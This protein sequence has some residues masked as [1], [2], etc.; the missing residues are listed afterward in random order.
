MLGE[1]SPHSRSQGWKTLNQGATLKA[2]GLWA[3]VGQWPCDCDGTVPAARHLILDKGSRQ[4]RNFAWRPDSTALT[5]WKAWYSDQCCETVVS[6]CIK[7]YWQRS[8]H[9]GNV[10]MP[11]GATSLLASHLC[12]RRSSKHFHVLWQEFLLNNKH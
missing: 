6:V 9:L 12:P 10:E 2:R 5:C 3:M 8:N 7:C 11:E 1:L 4:G